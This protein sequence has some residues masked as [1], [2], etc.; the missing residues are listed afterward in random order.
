[1]DAPATPY[2]GTLCVTQDSTSFIQA[3]SWPD[4]KCGQMSVRKPEEGLGVFILIM[5]LVLFNGIALILV[6]CTG[7]MQRILSQF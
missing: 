1:M 5:L 7:V 6:L 2:T 3:A 4:E